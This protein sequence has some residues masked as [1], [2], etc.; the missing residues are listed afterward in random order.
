[1]IYQ[2]IIKSAAA[3]IETAEYIMGSVN[4]DDWS[5]LMPTDNIPEEDYRMLTAEFGDVTQEMETAYKNAFNAVM[6]D[7]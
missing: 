1:M 6:E 3:G 4:A 5:V 7:Q 2:T